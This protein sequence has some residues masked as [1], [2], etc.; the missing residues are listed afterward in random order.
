MRWITQN[1]E[2]DP[3]IHALEAE[4][5][6][7][8]YEN[9][10][11]RRMV[12]DPALTGE[13]TCNDDVQVLSKIDDFMTLRLAAKSALTME[14]MGVRVNARAYQPDGG[15]MEWGILVGA[16]TLTSSRDRI[17]YIGDVAVN[18]IKSIGQ[19]YDMNV[20]NDLDARAECLGE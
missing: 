5:E 11:L 19:F 20:K 15:K 13:I 10:Y 14:P 9:T 18:A 16:E 17:R 8:R 2:L 7:L 1:R 6:R 12:D 3:V 4:N